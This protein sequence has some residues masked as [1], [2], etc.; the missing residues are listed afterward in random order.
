LQEAALR[1]FTARGFDDV[2]VDEVAEAASVS[3]MTFFRHFPTKEAVVLDDPYNPVIGQAVGAQDPRLPALERVCRG[4]RAAWRQME[5]PEDEATRLRLRLVAGHPG[6]RARMCEYNHRTEEIIVDVLC[7]DEVPILEARVAA[8][9]VL[10]ALTGAL[11]DWAEG[12]DPVRLGET[13]LS[14]LSLLAP[15][16]TPT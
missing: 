11:F 7:K 5:E 15:D 10:G 14:A 8:G 12:A 1:L 6:L 9:A 13:I 4:V 2:T 3:H 16:R